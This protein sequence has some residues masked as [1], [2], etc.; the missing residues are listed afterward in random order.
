M[1]TLKT[2]DFESKGKLIGF[3]AGSEQIIFDF[4]GGI[5]IEIKHPSTAMTT[6]LTQLGLQG[7]SDAEINFATSSITKQKK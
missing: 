7:L 4:V 1:T 3:Q 6:T 2:R 5:T